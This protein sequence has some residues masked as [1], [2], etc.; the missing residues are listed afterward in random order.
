MPLKE[1]VDFGGREPAFQRAI[2]NVDQQEAPFLEFGEDFVARLPFRGDLEGLE[3]LAGFAGKWSAFCIKIGALLGGHDGAEEDSLDVDGS[4]PGGPF[5]ALQAASDM[6]G[7]G[8][9]PAAVT[10]EHVGV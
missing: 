7:R 5:E 6:C 8:E 1:S 4:I 9:L 2:E 3:E 10:G